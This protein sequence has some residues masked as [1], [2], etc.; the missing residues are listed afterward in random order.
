MSDYSLLSEEDKEH[1]ELIAQNLIACAEYCEIYE[2]PRFE[3]REPGVWEQAYD[4]MVRQ[5]TAFRID[6]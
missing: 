5:V 6:K 3:D 4:F 2:S 1:L